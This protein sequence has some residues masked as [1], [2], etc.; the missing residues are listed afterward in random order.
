MSQKCFGVDICCLFLESTPSDD[1]DDDV[2]ICVL[3]SWK[4]DV[5]P[6]AS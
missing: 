6:G 5:E 3:M 4:V 1:D 2:A